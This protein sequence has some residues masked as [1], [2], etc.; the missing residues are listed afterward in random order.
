MHR[1]VASP[2]HL[3]PACKTGWYRKTFSL[4]GLVF[5]HQVWHFR[6]R[7]HEAHVTTHDVDELWQFIQAESSQKATNTCNTGVAAHFMDDIPILVALF[8][9]ALQLLGIS[10]H[11]P[12]LEHVK[13]T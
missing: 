1:L 11:G 2:A 7:P 10:D 8:H 13:E 4:P 9:L 12:E 6:A 5:L 3:P